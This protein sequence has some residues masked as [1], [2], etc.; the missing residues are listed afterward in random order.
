[1]TLGLEQGKNRLTPYSP[2]WASLYLD[3]SE[4]ILTVC[5]KLVLA[6]AHIGSTSIPDMVAKPIID[7]V[8]GVTSLDD[9]ERMVPAMES[10]G[11]D[12]PGNIGI[13]DDR[14]FGRDPGF[15]KFLV[16]VVVFNSTRWNNYIAFRDALCNDK[17]LAGQYA[18]LKSDI[19]EQHPQGRAKYSELKS[20]F[21]H[22]VL[23]QH[24]SVNKT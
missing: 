2:E 5:G 12:Y 9:A 6:I 4:K 20:R 8:A 15:R 21:I 7:L 24:R 3:E 23:T 11:Y 13:P 14:I 16:H 17:K 22:D 1:M 19:V 18:Q 10:I